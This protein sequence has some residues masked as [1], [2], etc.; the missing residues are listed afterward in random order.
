MAEVCRSTHEG[1]A[2]TLIRA[3]RGWERTVQWVLLAEPVSPTA[4]G[5]GLCLWGQV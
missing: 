5:T 3:V 1:A 2:E 4:L